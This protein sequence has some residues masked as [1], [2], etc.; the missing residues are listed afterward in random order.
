MA[1]AIY[2]KIKLSTPKAPLGGV[3]STASAV[4]HAIPRPS[5]TPSKTLPSPTMSSTAITTSASINGTSS[6]SSSSNNVRTSERRRN[7]PNKFGSDLVAH[8]RIKKD[9]G[10][11]LDEDGDSLALSQPPRKK[12]KAMPRVI[13]TQYILDKYKDKPPSLTLH[14]HPTHFRFD[15]QDGTFNYNSAMRSILEYIAQETIPADA[16]EVF[17]DA[18]LPFYEG[19]LIVHIHDHRTAAK[20]VDGAPTKP[21]NDMLFSLN[22]WNEHLTPSPFVPYPA[23]KPGDAKEEPVVNGDTKPMD[24]DSSSKLGENKRVFKTV[25]HPTPSSL[26][27][28]ICLLA[29]T[30]L[31]PTARGRNASV[32]QTPATPA[33]AHP[34]TV[35]TAPNTKLPTILNDK[36]SL[37]FEAD[38]LLSTGP[39][40]VLTPAESP[41]HAAAIID[42]LKHPLHS[43]PVPPK[44]TRKRTVKEMAVDEAKAAEEE[45][46]MLIM[47]E[48]HQPSTIGAADD[49]PVGTG[50]FEPSFKRWKALESIKQK[51][52]EDRIKKEQEKRQQQEEER[53]KAA[54]EPR[55]EAPIRTPVSATPVEQ[56][57][58]D[59]KGSLRDMIARNGAIQQ[60]QQQ[61]REHLAQQ[62]AAQA[63]AQA[64]AQA[65]AAAQAQRQQHEAA[66]A[67]SAAQAAQAQREAQA[68]AREQQH[69][70]QVA[71]QAQA[72]AAAVQ[73]PTSA[74]QQTSAT[75]GSPIA[76]ASSPFAHQGSPP[77]P[78]RTST[79]SSQPG[80]R[81]QSPHMS[82]VQ[83]IQ[84]QH[85]QPMP[86]SP[87]MHASPMM[88]V[89][90]SQ[91]MHGSPAMAHGSPLARNVG[92]MPGGH[93]MNQAQVMAHQMMMANARN[94]MA[95]NKAAHQMALG[96]NPEQQK[97]M[98]Q[99]AFLM[100]QA[101]QQQHQQQQIL[102]AQHAAA[103]QQHQ[104]P[105]MMDGMGGVAGMHPGMAGR[106][107][108]GGMP[109]G[110]GMHMNG[111]MGGM[112]MGM[113]G[114]P[115]MMV[116]N[117]MAGG[118]GMP[119]G[120]MNGAALQGYSPAQI[121]MLMAAR[122]RG[123]PPQGQ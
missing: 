90:T 33:S 27:A 30:P 50:G 49:G 107:F 11:D 45:R 82:N 14:M 79:H 59:N 81:Q 114:Y 91:P 96:Q 78:T 35:S 118:G 75:Q 120:M 119:M 12:L 52:E 88:R 10:A 108:M 37:T 39:S 115:Q 99:R 63:Q 25:L 24:I 55:P 23:Q 116:A 80:S 83:S 61:Q 93:V 51:H 122:G 69:A 92:M 13:T 22:R 29:L 15:Q 123:Q 110:G 40:L 74:P 9:R 77:M 109:G 47:D 5:P 104:Q 26:H 38:Y 57:P 6:V 101:Q 34:L 76:A 66:A 28:E 18:R 71:A 65:A 42:A 16:V 84:H 102:A 31:P 4:N 3:L 54:K 19:R 73:T 20:G 17:R 1:T 62:A 8:A 21:K 113:N 44:K 89:T 121:N 94:P 111:M 72:H 67:A 100:R 43:R 32:V 64:Q 86:G 98:M 117:G 87:A 46:L 103:A 36:T 68:Q 53:R 95:M 41:E 48:R 105:Q 85:N 97:M 58:L 70:A 60:A 2:P 7:A 106:G 56:S 112:Q